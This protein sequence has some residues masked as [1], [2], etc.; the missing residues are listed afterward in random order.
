[1]SSFR[2]RVDN[3]NNGSSERRE[4]DEQVIW[5]FVR[6]MNEKF[7][8]LENM[9]KEMGNMNG[10]LVDA[11]INNNKNKDMRDHLD[12]SKYELQMLQ[13]RLKAAA[14]VIKEI[15][16]EFPHRLY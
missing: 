5:M 16:R 14:E 11:L 15:Q 1:V 12:A 6:E 9:F 7:R 8:S 13:D 3:K 4:R 10:K 2:R